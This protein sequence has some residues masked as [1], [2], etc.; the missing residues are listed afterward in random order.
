MKELDHLLWRAHK[1]GI[2]GTAIA[3]VSLY[4]ARSHHAIQ[5][6]EQGLGRGERAPHTTRLICAL[7]VHIKLQCGLTCAPL[8]VPVLCCSSVSEIT[9]HAQNTPQP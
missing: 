2:N 9:G 8:I 1:G 7:A 4:R 3:G 6:A 5:S